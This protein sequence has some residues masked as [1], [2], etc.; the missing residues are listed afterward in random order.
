MTSIIL[1]PNGP[2]RRKNQR[3]FRFHNLHGYKGKRLIV[4]F[5]ETYLKPSVE[6]IE[7]TAAKEA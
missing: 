6:E 5:Y 3:Y 7:S 4:G 2:Q 1:M